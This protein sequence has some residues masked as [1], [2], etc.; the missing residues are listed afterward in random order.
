MLKKPIGFIFSFML[1]ILIVSGCG[2][3]P[4]VE[5]R[6]IE[7]SGGTEDQEI[8]GSQQESDTNNLEEDLSDDADSPLVTGI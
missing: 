1:I 3:K 2:A 8:E 4:T 5:D 6:S 7:V